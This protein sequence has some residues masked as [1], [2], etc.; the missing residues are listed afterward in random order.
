[1][2]AHMH[3]NLIETISTLFC[4]F[5]NFNMI[6][7]KREREGERDISRTMYK[8]KNTNTQKRRNSS[9]TKKKINTKQ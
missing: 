5:Y 7:G 2:S 9:K 4:C 8:L 6:S 3:M 1:M